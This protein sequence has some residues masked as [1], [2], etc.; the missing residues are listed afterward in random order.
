MTDGYNNYPAGV[1]DAD[2]DESTRDRYRRRPLIERN[3]GACMRVKIG[4]TWYDSDDQAICIQVSETE[5]QQIGAMDRLLAPEG[6]Y[7][8]FQDDDERTE[9]ERRKWMDG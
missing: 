3:Q 8:I 5:Q 2:I 7:A 1:T 9:E 4:D 6:K